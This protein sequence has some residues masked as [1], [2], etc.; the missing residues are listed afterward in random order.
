MQTPFG[1]LTYCSNIHA[2]ETWPRHLEQLQEYVPRIKAAVAADRPFGIGLRLSN[3]ASLQLSEPAALRGFKDWLQQMDCYVFTM[4]GF[5]YGDFHHTVVKDQV[6]APDWTTRQRVDYTLRLARILAVL[7]PEGMDGGISTSPLGYRFWYAGAGLRQAMKT[8]T[9]HIL[10]LVEALFRLRQE[11]GRFIHLDIEPEPDGLLGT[12][13][14]FLGWCRDWLL[15]EGIPFLSASLGIPEEAAGRVLRDHLQ[16]CYDICHFAVSYEDRERFLRD[17]DSLGFRIGK[18]QVSAALRA[19]MPAAAA[20]RQPVIQAFRELN[21]P[22][23]L[24]QVVARHRNGSLHT[25]PD[26]PEALENGDDPETTEWRA[27]FHVPVFLER[28]GALASTQS[29][30][31]DCLLAHRLQPL[32]NHLEVETY[33]WEVLPADQRLPLQDSIIRELSW[34]KQV[35]A[36]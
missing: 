19:D 23:Y 29:E 33:T 36:L 3:T 15:P 35:L 12:G 5:P 18:I 32:S 30:I 9:R 20:A 14:E 4:N 22:T 2:G 17:L 11:T 31:T 21:E 7:L 25:Y 6:H 26:L 16:L 10:E 13:A 8:S 24:H 28:F 1:Q 27:H 34:V